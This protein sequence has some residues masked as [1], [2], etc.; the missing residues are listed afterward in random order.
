MGVIMKE[1]LEKQL[2]AFLV[3]MSVPVLFSSG[4]IKFPRGAKVVSPLHLEQLNT[5]TLRNKFF[6]YCFTSNN[7][8]DVT[9]SLFSDEEIARVINCSETTSECNYKWDGDVEN[10][11]DTIRRSIIRILTSFHN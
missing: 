4:C 6:E 7:G 5:D 11:K 1:K 8:E 9:A 3:G 2:R 10:L